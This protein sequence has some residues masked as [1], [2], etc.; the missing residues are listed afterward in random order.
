MESRKIGKVEVEG[1]RWTDGTAVVRG[2]PASKCTGAGFARAQW[3]FGV[4]E[5]PRRFRPA[6]PRSRQVWSEDGI[7]VSVC[8]LLPGQGA[9]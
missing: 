6:S 2:G 4:W 5:G 9:T 1:I 7:D 3:T 8:V